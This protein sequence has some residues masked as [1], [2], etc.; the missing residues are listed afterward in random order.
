MLVINVGS[1]STKLAWFKGGEPQVLETI[2]YPSEEQAL[3]S[4]MRHQIPHRQAGV[5]DFL[6]KNGIDPEG[7][8]MVVSRGGLGKPAPAGAYEVDDAMCEDLLDG[9]YGKHPSALGPA[10]ALNFS[11][12]YGAQAIVV[13]PPSTDEFH[14]LARISGLPG[15][16]RKSA[17]HSLNQKMVARRLAAKLEVKYEQMNVVVAHLGGGITIGAHQKGQVIDCTHGLAEGPFTP[18]RAGSL[19]TLDLIDIAFAGGMDKKQLQKLLVGEGGLYAYL[20]TRD[21]Q[22]AEEMIRDGDEKAKFI[23]EAMAYQ[24]AKDIGAMCVVLK[25]AVDGIILTGGMA[26]SEL[27][28][29]AIKEWVEF[30]APVFVFP[31]ENEMTALAEGCLRVFLKEEEIKKYPDA[32]A[33]GICIST[34]DGLRRPNQN[35]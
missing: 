3:Y 22:R 1:T 34:R 18:E 14:P 23:L 31:G 32:G 13:D 4:S 10:I 16:E 15:I 7:I 8:D 6:Q 25:G 27:V 5:L 19:P 35:S 2:P 12:R 20:Q 26:H 21:V 11:R 9:Q 30:L 29:D 33:L 17:F 28:T 24:I